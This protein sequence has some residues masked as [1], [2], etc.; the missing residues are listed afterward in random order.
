MKKR[1]ITLMLGI[2]AVVM[3]VSVGF[4]GWVITQSVT[5]EQTGNIVVEDITRD[6]LSATVTFVGEDEFKFTASRAQQTGDW[7]LFDDFT[8]N[9]ENLSV[10]IK[11]E[12][13]NGEGDLVDS[14]IDVE[15]A[16]KAAAYTILTQNDVVAPQ[17]T[18]TDGTAKF[19]GAEAIAAKILTVEELTVA[20]SGQAAIADGIHYYTVEFSWGDA[21]KIG[22][23]QPVN[24]QEYFNG[25][26]IKDTDTTR[27][28][29]LT[30][31]TTVNGVEVKNNADAAEALLKGLFALSS[32]NVTAYQFTVSVWAK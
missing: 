7:L 13:R 14:N 11:V 18:Y 1:I 9:P 27:L 5:V 15:F 8:D 22:D 28:G 19:G 20:P 32:S 12:V 29:G 10:T 21:F 3:L 25:D 30:A 6:A 17:G 4:A 23:A 16:V 2:I 31:D 24:P 26:G